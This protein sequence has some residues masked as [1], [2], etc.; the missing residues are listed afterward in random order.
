M[1]LLSITIGAGSG[2]AEQTKPMK[3]HPRE[4]IERLVESSVSDSDY[5]NI[6]RD[7]AQTSHQKLETDRA[8]EQSSKALEESTRQRAKER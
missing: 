3:E 7:K 8:L 1:S 5:R 4:V 6:E 2:F